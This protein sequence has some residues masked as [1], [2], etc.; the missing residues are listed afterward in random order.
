VTRKPEKTYNDMTT[1]ERAAFDQRYRVAEARKVM[2]RL[3]AR[4]KRLRKIEAALRAERARYCD[5]ASG[6]YTAS[7]MASRA[8]DQLVQA[9]EDDERRVSIATRD[10]E[11]GIHYRRDA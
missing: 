10:I 6:D 1:A 2:K 11:D 4:I 9:I 7:C 8:L 3:P 5:A